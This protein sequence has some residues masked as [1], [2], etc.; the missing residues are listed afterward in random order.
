MASPSEFNILPSGGPPP[1]SN[2][3]IFRDNEEMLLFAAWVQGMSVDCSTHR[4]ALFAFIQS[5]IANK[6][7]EN[8]QRTIEKSIYWIRAKRG[9]YTLTQKGHSKMID[10]FGMNGGRHNMINE[11]EFKRSY[12]GHIFSAVVVYAS[13]KIEARVDGASIKGVD[14]CHTLDDLGVDF[15]VKS[16]SHTTKLLNWIIQDN[17]YSWQI[18]GYQP[19]AQQE[20][21]PLQKK[22]SEDEAIISDDDDQVFPEGKEIYKLHRTIERNSAVVKLAKQVGLRNDPLLRCQA[23]GFS[24]VQTYGSLGEGFIEAHHILPLSELTE[25]TETKIEDIALVCSNC[26]R[27]IHRRPGLS[28]NGLKNLLDNDAGAVK[29]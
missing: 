17:D 18:L 24:F 26:H 8:L 23:C 28:L 1:Q 10:K 13:G 4:L 25:E 21:T 6:S 22:Q 20:V 5:H 9:V 16:N 12:K 3:P 14:A 29:P 7:E 19:I 15:K 11:Y 27:M 2:L